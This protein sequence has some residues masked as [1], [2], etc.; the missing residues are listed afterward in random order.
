MVGSLPCHECS[1]TG[2]AY[3]EN[4]QARFHHEWQHLQDAHVRSLAWILTS[5]GLLARHS[6]LWQEQIASLVLPDKASLHAWLLQ[7]DQQPSALHEA[8]N[9]HKQRRLGHYAEN[10]L[11]FYLRHHGLLYAHGLQ[12]HGKGGGGGTV[13]E[14]DFLL[15]QA[16]DLVH[17]EIATKFYL[18]ETGAD[19]SH[20]PDLYDYLGPNLADTLGS[21][22]QKIFHQQLVLSQHP[23]AQKILP[24][25]VLAAQALIKGWLFYRQSQ[26]AAGLIEGL[27]AEHCRGYWWTLS[28]IE[29]L[30]IPYALILP[31]LQWL[32]PAQCAPDAV[33]EKGDL[34]E[35]LQRYF[36]G[37]N[38]PVMLAI[39]SKHGK[40]MQEFCR[41]MVVPDD[42][43]ARAG[44]QRR[45]HRTV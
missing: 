13:G 42:W 14:F 17:W 28:E 26:M 37:D 38:T 9:L 27:A 4:F 20:I 2:L 22:M 5:P 8:L 10:L 45:R 11:G 32:A 19:A 15:H 18:L 16:D 24:K 7:L 33:M 12:V 44:E 31:R 35:V 30:A 34:R 40:V 43:L 21:K 25:K 23:E 1:F 6:P 29:Q 41:G 36:L 39:M 3:M